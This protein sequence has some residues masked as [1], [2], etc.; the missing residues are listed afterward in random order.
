LKFTTA[1]YTDPKSSVMLLL[2]MTPDLQRAL[3]A[4][5]AA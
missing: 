2:A 3:G 4:S 1:R 5:P